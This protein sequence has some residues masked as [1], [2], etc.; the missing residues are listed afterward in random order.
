M[1]KRA[2]RVTKLEALLTRVR[3]NAAA[4]RAELA[5][6]GVV[7]A[8]VAESEDASDLESALE[9]ARA[10]DARRARAAPVQTQLAH[11]DFAAILPPSSE[12]DDWTSLLEVALSEPPPSPNDEAVIAA[13]PVTEDALRAAGAVDERDELPGDLELAGPATT[14]LET[15][16]RAALHRARAPDLFATELIERRTPA[17]PAESKPAA[18]DSPEPSV[19][20]TPT[21]STSQ[22]ELAPQSSPAPDSRRASRRRPASRRIPSRP[23]WKRPRASDVVTPT[24]PSVTA[25][26]SESPRAASGARS[27]LTLALA[28]MGFLFG[29][30]VVLLRCGGPAPQRSNPS[31]APTEASNENAPSPK[32]SLAL[33]PA[34][35]ATPARSTPKTP[36]SSSTSITS[37]ASSSGEPAAPTIDNPHAQGLLWVDAHE[38]AE[39]Y[40]NGGLVG[41]T[42]SYLKV[43]CGMKNVRLAR[44]GVPPAGHSFPA[45]LTPG[46][47]VV[48]PCGGVNR[49]RLDPP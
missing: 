21:P 3:V 1:S 26:P 2:E 9:R 23:D 30:G 24:P 10:L 7:I 46:E 44:V 34:S 5:A 35:N 4:R 40:V 31:S 27:V 19:E 17:P 45:W 29:F 16:I 38:P 6:A 14:E 48:I 37:A 32:S 36:P 8:H 11:D 20:P 15:A 28:A 33:Q 43:T 13:S 25:A 22:I 47:S 41:P 39:V 12:R 49:V 42:S 18:P